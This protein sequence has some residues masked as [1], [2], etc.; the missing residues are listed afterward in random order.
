MTNDK[1]SIKYEFPY[2]TVSTSKACNNSL[3]T[4][5]NRSHL[6]VSCEAGYLSKLKS[7]PPKHFRCCENSQFALHKIFP[8]KFWLVLCQQNFSSSLAPLGVLGKFGLSWAV[9]ACYLVVVACTYLYKWERE[10]RE[11]ARWCEDAKTIQ[12]QREIRSSLMFIGSKEE[13]ERDGHG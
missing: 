1:L 6:Q 4:N 8:Q 2:Q 11:S 9:A 5:Q 12:T 10:G 3:Y 13:R 7:F